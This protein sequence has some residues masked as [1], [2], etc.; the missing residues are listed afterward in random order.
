MISYIGV[1]YNLMNG[2]PFTRTGYSG[3]ENGERKQISFNLICFDDTLSYLEG[4][5]N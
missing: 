4:I 1:F 5:L 2:K 3:R